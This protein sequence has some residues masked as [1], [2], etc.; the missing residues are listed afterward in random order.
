M[1]SHPHFAEEETEAPKGGDMSKSP[2]V[3]EIEKQ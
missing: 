3:L 2:C 1:H